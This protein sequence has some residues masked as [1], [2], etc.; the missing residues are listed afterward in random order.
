MHWLQIKLEIEIEPRATPML[1]M[2]KQYSQSHSSM[3]ALAESQT[4][5]SVRGEKSKG[6][7]TKSDGIVVA[8]RVSSMKGGIRE[9]VHASQTKDTIST[10]QGLPPL[11]P[12]TQQFDLEE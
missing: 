1:S 9:D 8:N 5:A 7:E 10:E 3:T 11:K 12:Q 4:S 2:T 6:K